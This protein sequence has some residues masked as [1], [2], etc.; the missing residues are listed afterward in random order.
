MKVH[1][2]SIVL[3]PV[4]FINRIK[5]TKKLIIRLNIIFI[6]MILISMSGAKVLSPIEPLLEYMQDPTA[7]SKAI[8]MI[9]SSGG[10]INLL[11]TLEY[12]ILMYLVI[13]KYDEILKNDSDTQII[14]KLFLVLLPLFTLFRNIEIL[15]RIKDYFIISYG[16]LLGYI[17]KV[18]SNKD[19]FKNIIILY[20]CC[21]TFLRFIILFDGG[22]LMP[23]SSYLIKGLGIFR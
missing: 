21:F 4:Y 6:P 3:L 12:F 19:L 18:K 5:V 17:C 9:N 22:A 2:A 14:I 20:Y 13:T 23:Y 16:I 15:T 1:T 8:A 11:H 7:Q 10:G